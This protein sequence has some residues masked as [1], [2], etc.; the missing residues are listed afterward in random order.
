MP[1]QPVLEELY[2]MEGTHAGAMNFFE[3]YCMNEG[4]D[5]ESSSTVASL[6]VYKQAFYKSSIQKL[7]KKPFS[8]VILACCAVHSDLA[9]RR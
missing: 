7:Q 2:P 9:H 8:N 4:P 6:V 3:C 5:T 1:E